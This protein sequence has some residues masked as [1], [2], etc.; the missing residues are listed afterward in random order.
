MMLLYLFTILLLFC[1]MYLF[2]YND[3]ELKFDNTIKIK[4][5]KT[6]EKFNNDEIITGQ[7]ANEYI[8]SINQLND[9]I[10]KINNNQIKSIIDNVTKIKDT[11]DEKNDYILKKINEIYW[12]RYLEN[13]NQ[14]NASVFNEYLKYSEPKK[15]KFYQQYL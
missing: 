11:K 4:P 2:I 10:T 14:T 12:K 9:T 7:Q 8:T 6:F 15:N 3:K 5:V 13:I 1:I